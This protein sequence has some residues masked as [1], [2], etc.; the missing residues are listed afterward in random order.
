MKASI[1]C[2]LFA[3]S[4][5]TSMGQSWALLKKV[6][7]ANIDH[8]EFDQLG[9]IYIADFHG[10]VSK[11]DAMGNLILEYAPV[12]FAKIHDM[13]AGTQLK[14][15]LFYD[16]L[17]ELVILDRYLSS[18]VKYRL[19][20]YD[21]GYVEEIT[22]NIQ[23]SIWVLDVSNFSLKLIDLS[24]NRVLE[25]K[26]LARI[27]DEQQADIQSFHTHQN[28]LY[29][30]DKITGIQVFDNI[31][32]HLYGLPVLG[33]SD[34]GFTKDYLYYA[35]DGFIKFIHLY[36]TLNKTI[37]LPVVST[38]KIRFSGNRLLVSTDNGFDI[39]KYLSAE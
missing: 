25:K 18:P 33:L 31:G 26:T 37:A 6:E 24:N 34:V 20:D 17:Q 29:L 10:T 13:S 19:T 12:Q 28:R 16:N 8:I 5:N 7:H 2:L 36:K 4:T 3:I 9:N 23:P 32:N 27:L 30:I 1:V 11:Y 14:V 38:G 22:L 35:Q 21:V 39:Y 15:Y